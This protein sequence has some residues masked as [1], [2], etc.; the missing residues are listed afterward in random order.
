MFVALIFA[1]GVTALVAIVMM[2][3]TLRR[4]ARLTIARGMAS[5]ALGIGVVAAAALGIV[6]VSAQPAQ[7]AA[8]HGVVVDDLQ[9]PTK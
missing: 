7:A 4:S 3:V 6:A 9:L 8:P 1:V 2:L 5:A